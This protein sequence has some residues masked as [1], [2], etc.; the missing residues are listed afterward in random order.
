MADD[1]LKGFTLNG[2]F[3]RIDTIPP[4]EIMKFGLEVTKLIGPM[5]GGL[6][7]VNLKD[8][9]RDDKILSLISKASN[10]LN[11]ELAEQIFNRA[12]NYVITPEMTYLKNPAVRNEWFLKHPEDIMAVPLKATME[13]ARDFLLPMLNTFVPSLTANMANVSAS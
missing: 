1:Q 10:G 5:I 9:Y 13:I 3:Y 6:E 2:R 8:K 7:G 4:D 11:I 12:I